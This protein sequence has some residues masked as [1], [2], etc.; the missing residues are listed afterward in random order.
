MLL[1]TILIHMIQHVHFSCIPNIK[2][3]TQF[4]SSNN[5]TLDN[6]LK[7]GY[8]LFIKSVTLLWRRQ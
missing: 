4:I 6:K 5:K 8:L 7:T 3:K 2:K 1:N